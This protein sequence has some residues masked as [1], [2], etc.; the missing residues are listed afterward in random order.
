MN[1]KKFREIIQVIFSIIFLFSFWTNQHLYAQ[2]KVIEPISRV[3]YG[4]S[5]TNCTD[6]EYLYI[7]AGG[8]VIIG[9]II[10]TDSVSL[11]SEC[12]F[13]SS[14]ED[15]LISSETLYVSDLLTGLHI[16]DVKNVLQPHEIGKKYFPYRSYGMILDSTNLFISHGSDGVSKVDITNRS[17]PITLIKAGFPCTKLRIYSDYLYCINPDNIT[18]VSIATLDSL[19]AISVFDKYFGE[20]IGLEFS[21]NKG[22]LVENYVDLDWSNSIL[23]LLDIS[24][25]AAPQKRSS[26]GLPL[27]TSFKNKGD[28]VL[29]FTGGTLFII[30]AS[31]FSSPFIIAETPGIPGG[32]VS[33]RDTLM[34]SSNYQSTFQLI[35]IKDIVHPRKGFHLSTLA[36]IGSVVATDSFL[37][38][39]RFDYSGLFLVDIRDISSPYIKYEYTDNIGSVR[40]LQISNGRIFVASQ[41]GLKIFDVVD[42]E[43]LKLIGELNYGYWVMKIDVLDTL[44]ACGGYYYDVHLISVAN[45]TKPKYITSI[46]MPPSMVVE[47]IFLRDTLLFVNGDYGGIKIYS[48]SSPGSPA[49]L[50]EK[51]YTSCE[52]SYPFGKILFVSDYSTL[53]AFDISEPKNPIELGSFDLDRRITD[54]SIRDSL[55][56][57]S[58]FSNGYYEDNGMVILDVRVLNSMKEVAR[59]NTPGWSNSISANGHYVFLTDDLDGIYIYDRNEIITDVSTFSNYNIPSGYKLFQ[60]YPNPFNPNTKIKFAIPQ[61]SFVN[62]KVFD[63]LGREI[64]MLVNEEKPAGTYEVTWDATNL[65]SGVYFYRLRAGSIVNTKKMILLK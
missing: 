12:Y 42:L 33:I 60:N 37:V 17:N 27:Q 62:L 19:N 30:D 7:G 63:V 41:Q 45:P 47:D 22:I 51:Y 16:I 54:I 38:A 26:L 56:F 13:P 39:G 52:A 49:L 15:L 64:E 40:G 2:K 50:W 10:S 46:T 31:S 24:V 34:L 4:N 14:V 28:T 36:D 8:T 44:A 65:P 5:R 6:G 48:T 9:R 57:I 18:I 29:C 59:A 43:K 35:S 1:R 3:F 53:H 11:L 21:N 58:V 61:L 55:A 25:P 32:F 23:T 20:I